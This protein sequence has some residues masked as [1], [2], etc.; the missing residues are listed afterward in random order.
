MQ[1]VRQM[2]SS[3]FLTSDVEVEEVGS[4][5]RALVRLAREDYSGVVV[6]GDHLAEALRI[7]K[8]LQNEQI[9]EGMPDGIVLLDTDNTIVWGNGRL[10]E[11][12]GHDS[13]VGMNFYA[14]LNSPEILGP[15][16]CPFHSAL[17][18]G[19]DSGST[20]RSSDNR[21]FQVHVAPV[22]ERGHAPQ[23]LIVTVR[24]VTKEMLQQQ[25]LA[26]IHQAGME[27]ADLTPDD[28]AAHDGRRANRVAQ[29]E[30]LALH[31]RSAAIRRRR[32]SLARP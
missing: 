18:T 29:V 5:L 8:L 32:N 30:H 4:P 1:S 7:G 10:R 17:S 23:H 6:V 25:K 16:F 14:A 3:R 15:D 11:W 28:L 19:K 13:V 20:L 27:L 26:A 22:F 2:R 12:S 24:D 9:L 21:Y 31:E